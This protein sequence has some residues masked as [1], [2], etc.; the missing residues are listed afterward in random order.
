MSLADIKLLSD[1][2]KK[3]PDELGSIHSLTEYQKNRIA[4]I[5]QRVIGVSTLNH[6]S[7]SESKVVQN[8]R[9]FG[10]ENFFQ[11]PAVKNRAMKLG[12]GYS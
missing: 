12:L 8:I 7:I 6:I 2:N 11:V 3:Y 9:A 1:L 10:L 4:D 5:R